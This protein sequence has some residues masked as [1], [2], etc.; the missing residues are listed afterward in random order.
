V[1][2]PFTLP[3]YPDVTAGVVRWPLSVLRLCSEDP[4]R[5]TAA[6]S[7]LLEVWRGYSDESVGVYAHSGGEPHNTATPIARFRGGRYALDAVLRNN[8]MSEEHPP[9]IF[10]P[11]AEYHHIKKENIGLIEVMGMAILARAPARRTTTAFPS[12]RTVSSS[13]CPRACAKNYGK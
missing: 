5:L 13:S 10:H 9:G 1:E 11:H 2:H 3:V 8:R 6:A 12:H 7:H 4:E